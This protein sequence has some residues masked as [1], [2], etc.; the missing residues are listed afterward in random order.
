MVAT[1]KD[2]IAHRAREIMNSAPAILYLLW[3][4]GTLPLP[5]DALDEPTKAVIADLKTARLAHEYRKIRRGLIPTRR[6]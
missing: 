5:D 2:K 6:A 1:S 4:D 3:L